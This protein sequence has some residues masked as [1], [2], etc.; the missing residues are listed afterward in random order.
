M[1]LSHH[2][3]RIIIVLAIAVASLGLV[4][5]ASARL[6]TDE[7]YDPNVSPQVPTAVTTGDGFSWGDAGIGAG[8]AIGAVFAG[9]GVAYAARHRV[10][11]AT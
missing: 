6:Y 11:V 1:R 7:R 2:K 4:S 8:V 9:L 3:I 10:R 5:S